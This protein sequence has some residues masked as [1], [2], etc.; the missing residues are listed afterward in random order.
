MA[1]AKKKKGSAFSSI[2]LAVILLIGLSLVLYPTFSNWYNQFHQTRAIA[3]YTE[4][5]DN[6]AIAER[7]RMREEAQQ[8]NEDLWS[9]AN[10][11]AP[12]EEEHQRYLELLDVTGTGI[13]GYINIPSINVNI[14]IYH[15]A[16]EEVLQ[17][18]V[19]HIEG[20]S[21][22]VGGDGTH[23]V[24]S[25]HRGLPSAKLF[26][27]LDQLGEGDVFMLSVLGETLTYEIDQIRIVLPTEVDNLT[28]ERGHDYVTLV[29]CTPYGI[30][31]HRMLV[32]AH[33]IENA[34]TEINVK[35]DAVLF[36][37][38]KVAPF[39]AAPVLFVLLMG[40]IMKPKRKKVTSEDVRK[41]SE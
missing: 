23:C 37:A 3:N 11:Y 14:A 13:M 20:T 16:T 19:G 30:N 27:D 18:A 8:Y 36:D 17:T 28:M 5:V 9:M 15:T 39:L 34:E 25:G 7:E 32:R 4:F 22:P 40:I 33:R 24:L 31:S 41:M 21:L 12:S 26:T 6:I 35:A 38:M 29:T 10:R 2:L 1:K